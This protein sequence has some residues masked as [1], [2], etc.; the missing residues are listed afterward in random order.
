V[1]IGIVFAMVIAAIYCL[2]KQQMTYAILAAF[3]ALLYGFVVGRD[4]LEHLFHKKVSRNNFGKMNWYVNH[5]VRM[6]F[7]F[8]TAIGAFTAV[9]NIFPLTVLNFTVPALLGFIVIPKSTKFFIKKA[10]IKKLVP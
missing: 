4:V 9:Q 8:V 2:L 3:F 7:S 1:A 5:V 10:N 6:Q